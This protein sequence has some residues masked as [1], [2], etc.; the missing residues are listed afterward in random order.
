MADNEIKITLTAEDKASVKIGDLANVMVKRLVEAN[1]TLVADFKKLSESGTASLGQIEQAYKGMVRQVEANNRQ[2]AKVTQDTTGVMGSAWGKV[3]GMWEGL[4][5]AWVGISAA[6]ATA[7]FL[8]SWMTDALN[9][10]IAFNKL[11]IQIENL[12]IS[13]AKVSGSVEATIAATSKYAIVQEED[14]AKVLQQ[15]ILY[16]GDLTKSQE[17]LNLAYDLAY[18]KGI[19][20]S[21]AATM[22]GKALTGNAEQLGRVMPEF[23]N[24]D[25]VLGKNRTQ[26]QETAY[27]MAVLTEKVAGASDKMTEHERAAKEV[28][29]TWKDITQTIG[30]FLLLIAEHLTKTLH[31]VAAAALYLSGTFIKLF[32]IP[33]YFIALFS[34]SAAKA[35]KEMQQAAKDAQGAAGELMDEVAGLT[36]ET[37]G[38]GKA[39]EQTAKQIADAFKKESDSVDAV[40]KKVKDA[41]DERIKSYKEI[42]SNLEANLKEMEAD[43]KKYLEHIKALDNEA[44]KS[45]EKTQDRIRNLKR[46]LM[47]PEEE[48]KD[49]KSEAEDLE[50]KARMAMYAKEYDKAKEYAE[51][52]AAIRESLAGKDVES[53]KKQISALEDLERLNQDIIA[54]EKKNTMEKIADNQAAWKSNFAVLEQTKQLLKELTSAENLIQVSI[55]LNLIDEAN[56]LGKML[57][58]GRNVSIDGKSSDTTNIPDVP[59]MATGGRLPGYGG[60]DRIP[61]LAEGGEFM[62]RKEAVNFWG[63]DLY[64]AMNRF[65]VQRVYDSLGLQRFADGGIVEQAQAAQ[66]QQ[67][68]SGGNTVNLNLTL[69]GKT[70]AA[71]T[72]QDT[73][74]ELAKEIERLHIIHGRYQTPY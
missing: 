13:Y 8:K 35:Y 28:A 29:K 56:F 23:R 46:G 48:S 25:E 31:T 58:L 43:E 74:K 59:G 57:Q 67:A 68:Q 66:R 19:D 34:T 37:K 45:K 36:R 16:T 26:A 47:S 54:A 5:S 18:M 60:G 40:R 42:E 38:H 17:N 69:G 30:G 10:E 51:K 55:R 52:A 39:A 53:V 32:S 65:D 63:A 70:F 14:V 44:L 11:K 49:K 72:S 21:E 61:I 24:L 7:Y 3:R 64:A 4:K 73:A 1:Q 12:G 62:S 27:A 20:V 41:K 22:I 50:S 15:L 33:V 71:K 6:I 9:A 2:M